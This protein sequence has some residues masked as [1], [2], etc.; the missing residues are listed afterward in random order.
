MSMLSAREEKIALALAAAAIPSGEILAGGDDATVA[1][2]EQWLNEGSTLQA[3]GV[4]GLLWAAEVGAVASTG[5][6]LSH[7][8]RA[9]TEELLE[10]WRVSSSH[11]R[12][13]FVRALL[14][15]IKI[16]HF[17]HPSTQ[18][19]VGCRTSASRSLTTIDEAQ[20][21]M[22]Q[23]IDGNDA[24][25]D[26]DLEC[27][28][29]VIGSGAGGAACAY[30]LASRGRAVVLLEE[31]DFHRR[32]SFTARP[33][34]MSRKLYR[35]QG[36]TVALGN[37][38]IPVWAGRAVGGS[39]VINS[40]TC[41]RTTD[42]IFKR[43]RDEMG[44]EEFSSDSLDPYFTRVESMLQVT[45]AKMNLTGGVGRVISRGASALGMSHHPLNRNAP[46]CDGQGVCCFGCP[47]GAKRSTDVSYVPETLKRGGVLVTAARAEA[48]D[49]ERG[50]AKAVRGTLGKNGRFRIRAQATV[51]AGGALMT[52]VILKRAGLLKKTPYVGKNLS[53]HPASKVMAIFDETIDMANGIPQGYAVDEYKDEG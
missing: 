40:G 47:T 41:Y 17:D 21:W 19:K 24:T 46:D 14:S 48:F 36:M 25:E 43:W 44:L 38:G 49:I 13:S 5:H 42:R 33:A 45:P 23:I 32:S 6:T 50:Q 31:G 30:E 10:K 9:R 8:P 7:L 20:R 34:E 28:V 37:V 27:D 2:L 16:A 4:R 11:A 15:P 52:P 1:R 39:T 51:I 53:I 18:E 12:R 22:Q 35:D 29:V 3:R 26:L